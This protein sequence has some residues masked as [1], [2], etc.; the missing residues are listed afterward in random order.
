MV[1]GEAGGFVLPPEA[2]R[3][4]IA[5]FETGQA[6][7]TFVLRRPGYGDREL[8]LRRASC[9]DVSIDLGSIELELVGT[10]SGPLK[11]ESF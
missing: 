1:T 10:P 8:K 9:D 3:K 7:D 11:R 5:P 2:R 6:T 4:H